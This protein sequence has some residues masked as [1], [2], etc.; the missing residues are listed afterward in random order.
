[1]SLVDGWEAYPENL[2]LSYPFVA[3]QNLP[4]CNNDLSMQSE[5]LF[6]PSE[7][8]LSLKVLEFEIGNGIISNIPFKFHRLITHKVRRQQHAQIVSCSKMPTWIC[9]SK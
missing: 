2:T 8:E 9:S 3:V 4:Q 5:R 6:I 1:M 7:D